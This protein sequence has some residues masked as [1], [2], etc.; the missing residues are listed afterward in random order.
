M[1]FLDLHLHKAIIFFITMA[2]Q[3]IILIA[4]LRRYFDNK[5]LEIWIVRGDPVERRARSPHQTSCDFFLRGY[6]KQNVHATPV[7]STEDLK[8]RIR[9]GADVPVSFEEILA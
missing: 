1:R 8:S 3:H 2:L 4:C 9:R 6:L 5:R 7:D